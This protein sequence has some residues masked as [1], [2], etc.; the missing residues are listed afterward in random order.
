M[1]EA[2]R[3]YQRLR[4][5]WN[6]PRKTSGPRKKVGSEP[7][8]PGRDPSGLADVLGSVSD[9]LGWSATLAQHEVFARWAEVVGPDVA[10]HSEPVDLDAGTLTVKCDSTAWATQLG[11]LRHDLVRQVQTE[12]PESGVEHIRFLGPNAPSWKKGPRV[13]PGRG[14]RDTYG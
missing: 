12:L 6:V 13:T 2:Q 5:L 14:P 8:A 1:N 9:E 7:F 3:V 10:A 11:L 4:T